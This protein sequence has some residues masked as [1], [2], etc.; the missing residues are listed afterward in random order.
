MTMLLTSLLAAGAYAAGAPH[1]S[2]MKLSNSKDGEATET[3]APDTPKI[4]L[5]AGLVDVPSGSKVSSDWIAE[6]TGGAAPANYKIDSV[7]LDV[8]MITNEV[9]FSLSKPN[10]GWP[11]GKYRVELFI[12][13][14]AAGAKHFEVSKDADGD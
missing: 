12:D 9:T 5:Q 6:D 14:K 7:T 13:G 10:A 3:F 4:F 2:D 11:L 8:G 1:Y